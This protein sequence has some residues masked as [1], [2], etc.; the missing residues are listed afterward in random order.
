METL[1]SQFVAHPPIAPYRV[2]A[3]QPEHPLVAG[4]EPF[5]ADDELY[6]RNCTRRSRSCCIRGGPERPRVSP[7]ATGPGRATASHVPQNRSAPAR[8]S[9]SR[10]VTRGAISTCVRSRTNIASSSAAAGPCRRFK[11]CCVAAF[12]GPRASMRSPRHGSKPADD[13]F[14]NASRRP[15]TAGDAR[16][17]GN[18]P[19]TPAEKAPDPELGHETIGKER[20]TS[21][22]FMRLEWD[23][24]WTKVWLLGG[25]ESDLPEPGDYVSTAIGPESVL[26][27][28]QEEAG[29]AGSITCACIAATGCAPKGSAARIRSSASTITGNTRLTARSSGSRTS[30]RFRRAPHPVAASSKC[31]ATRG[32]AL[33]GSA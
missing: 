11:N 21:P 23:R 4:I 10:S 29:C 27:V 14:L 28:R 33:S 13:P 32:A 8:C 26:L 3:T 22:E 31:G 20:Y 30:R 2:E 1:G 16:A 7:S 9:I 5:E 12:A 19:A 17:T 18:S 6:Y 24:I 25:L 15:R